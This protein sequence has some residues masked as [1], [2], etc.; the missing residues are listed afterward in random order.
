MQLDEFLFEILVPQCTTEGNKIEVTFH[1]KW[2]EKVRALANG[3]TIRRPVKGQWIGPTGEV[4]KEG[5][6]P[7]RIMCSES[8]IYKIAL[9]TKEFYKQD[10]VMYYKLSDKVVIV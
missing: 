4:L 10:A 8:T 9:M 1:H 7:V 3:L 5:M 2:D 6:I